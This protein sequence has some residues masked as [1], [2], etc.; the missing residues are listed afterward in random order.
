MYIDKSTVGV[1]PTRGIIR[2][3][4]VASWLTLRSPVNFERPI[5]FAG[6]LEVAEAYNELI[7]RAMSDYSPMFILTLED[8][9]IVPNNAHL[10]LLEVIPGYMAVSGLY[11]VKNDEHIPLVFDAGFRVK[12]IA[13]M[14][15]LVES[16]AVPMGC[17]LW[18]TDLFR[19]MPKPWFR[20]IQ[21][22]TETMTHDLDFCRRAK[23][24]RGA[25]FAVHLDVK[26][27][28]IDIRSGKVY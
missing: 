1:I 10:K 26:V 27:G 3:E 25:R 6:G 22:E 20:T 2:Y 23:Q 13:G 14:T 15:G 21:N 16:T 8:D 17:T 18:R 19:H 5:I 4:V 12:D 24:D 9:N 28:H 7:E 11:H